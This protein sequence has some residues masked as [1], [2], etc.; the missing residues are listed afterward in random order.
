MPVIQ[1]TVDIGGEKLSSQD[2]ADSVEFCM[3]VIR[4]VDGT[5]DMATGKTLCE[6]ERGELTC[7]R[8]KK[9]E[10]KSDLN[11]FRVDIVNGMTVNL[12]QGALGLVR[13]A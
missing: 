9:A 3:R 4:K 13:A 1:G 2:V 10:L 7:D 5:T 6:D 12:Q 11:K 8:I